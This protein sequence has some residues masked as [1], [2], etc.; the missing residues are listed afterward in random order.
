[1]RVGIDFGGVLSETTTP[2]QQEF[3]AVPPRPGSLEEIAAIKQH[4]D[5]PILISKVSNADRRAKACLWLERYGFNELFEDNIK[6][7]DKPEGKIA[8]ARQTGITVMIDDT[9]P[10]LE[11]L[12]EVEHKLLFNSVVAPIG[13]IAV[14][15][16]RHTG[17]VLTR[18]RLH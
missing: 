15:D 4:G 16:W 14:R 8:L 10:Q 12:N 18:L 6:F 17:K 3:L 1:M 5:I 13:M 9:L 11:L 2:P 7:C